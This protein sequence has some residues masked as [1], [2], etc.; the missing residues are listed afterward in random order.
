MKLRH[1][2]TTLATTA[3]I[4]SAICFAGDDTL[5]LRNGSTLKGVYQG[6]TPEMIRFNFN[7]ATQ[8]YSRNDVASLTFAESPPSMPINSTTTM[9]SSSPAMVSSTMTVNSGN[10]IP[11][12]TNLV[13]S[14]QTAIHSGR[15]ESG[16]SFPA[17]LVSDVRVNDQ[18]V[19]NAGT[20]LQGQIVS[21][22]S[23]GFLRK[24]AELTLTINGINYKGQI[25][26]VRTSTQKDASEANTGREMVGGA[27]RG[28][29]LG[30]IVGAIT[31]DAGE[32]AAAGAAAGGASGLIK[33]GD[34]VEYQAG[35]VLAFTLES[36]VQL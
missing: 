4:L 29:A 8:E 27:A 36:P 16:Q 32:G 9:V 14:L 26:P 34:D 6:G 19:L 35:S 21:A 18:V 15:G 28:A 12:G 33:R 11:A 1:I 25:I 22:Q 24:S 23:A 2:F 3:I 31:G 17:I 13:A 10:T 7:G 30:A 5:E 20:V